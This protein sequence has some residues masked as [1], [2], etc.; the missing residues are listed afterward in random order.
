MTTDCNYDMDRINHIG[1]DLVAAFNDGY[2]QGLADAKPKWIP[3][4]ER[5]P[6]EYERVLTCDELGNIHI[7]Y[8]TK[9]Y[10]YPFNIS[11]THPRYFMPKW[12]M[13]LPEPPESEGE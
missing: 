3:V 1:N 2:Q 6:D 4:I 13:P 9:I 12:W 11:P 10:A 7:M 5:L 8:H